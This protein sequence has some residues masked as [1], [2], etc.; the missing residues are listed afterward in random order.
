MVH[1]CIGV[2]E[3]VCATLLSPPLDVVADADI[4]HT[5]IK[6]QVLL[7]A[8]PLAERFGALVIFA[9]RD[10]HSSL[11]LPVF[12]IVIGAD[13]IEILTPADF[14]APQV[15][16]GFH[17]LEY[18]PETVMHHHQC[19]ISAPCVVVK[20]VVVSLHPFGFILN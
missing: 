7:V 6:T 20:R 4:W 17:V 12:P 14:F 1:V 9:E 5:H 15:A 19:G 2:N 16:L 11:K 10:K 8:V 3:L 13:D 18:K